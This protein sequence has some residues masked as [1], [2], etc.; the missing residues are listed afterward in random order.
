MPSARTHTSAPRPDAR[1]LHL[2]DLENL[3][4]DPWARG[5][6]A[7]AGLDEY[8]V[9]SDWHTCDLVFVAGNPWLM[10]ELGWC[11]RVDCHLFAAR[12]HDAADRKLL[13]AAPP[14]WV[15][16]RFA[17]VTIGSGDGIFAE[18]AQGLR[19]LGLDV[20]VVA[21]PDALSS[22]LRRSACRV[23]ILPSQPPASAP[24]TSASRSND[25]ST[26]SWSSARCRTM[27]SV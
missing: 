13:E 17:S 10:I 5:P 14:D 1:A 2:V 3:L 7:V 24:R 16:K 26:A 12:G 27:T 22:R 4:G 19:R 23:V 21:R 15:A 8:L 6:V 25:R 20:Q 9:A 11:C 18:C